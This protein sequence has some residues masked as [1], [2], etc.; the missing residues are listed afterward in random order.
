MKGGTQSNRTLKTEYLHFLPEKKEVRRMYKTQVY[1]DEKL[2]KILYRIAKKR[3]RD[4]PL[5]IADKDGCTICMAVAHPSDV[6]ETMSNVFFAGYY[7]IEP[8]CFC[9][10]IQRV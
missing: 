5:L 2:R 8:Y 7:T 10:K 9:F 6:Q 4:L 1:S 3:K